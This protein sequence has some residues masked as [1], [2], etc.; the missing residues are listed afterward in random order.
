MTARL[1]ALDLVAVLVVATLWV[2]VAAVLRTGRSR[3]ALGLLAAAVLATAARVVLVAVLARSGWWFVQ[4]KV[5]LTVPLVVVPGVAA[6]VLAARALLGGRRPGRFA[7]ASAA[8]AAGGAATGVLGTFVVGYPVSTAAAVVLPLLVVAAAVVVLGPRVRVVGSG[9]VGLVLAGVVGGAWWGSRVPDRVEHTGHTG[10]AHHAVSVADLRGPPGEPTRRFT[11]TARQADVTL[12]GGRSV[13]AWTFDGQVPGPQLTV[14]QGDLVEVLLRN[15][16]I[17]DG[18]TIHWHGYPVPA[19]EDGVAGV[20]QDAVPPGGSFTYRFRATEPGTYWYHA[21]QRSLEAVRR[22]L[23]GA[24]VVRPPTP[25]PAAP[26]PRRDRAAAP[27][28]TP[29]GVDV[30]VPLHTMDGTLLTAPPVPDVAPRVPVRL[31]LINTDDRPHALVLHGTPYRLAAVDGRELAGG[32]PLGAD[33]VLPLPAGGR[34]DLVFTQPPRSVRLAVDGRDTGVLLGRDDG[35]PPPVLGGRL[36]DVTRYAP[37]GPPPWGPEPRFAVDTTLVLDRTLGFVDGLPALT[38]P[39]NGAVY[40]AV[41]DIVVRR[42]DLVRMTIVNRGSE[43][44]PMHPHGHAVLVLARDG[45]PASGPLWMD[46]FEVGPGEV[47]EVA[48][49]AD[50]PGLWMNHCHNLEHAVAG[51]VGHLAYEGVS[52][53]F[54]V[55]NATGNHPE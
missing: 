23:Y 10:H 38:Y 3:L 30:V 6:A 37:P 28:A 4:E 32:G 11:L 42:G 45:R 51:M 24:L 39:I 46:S 13:H 50:N 12:P 47:W 15:A 43:P 18:V 54:A 20:T 40:P 2:A 26:A 22:G 44:H 49:R 1:L 35:R 29:P 21:H 53:P 36:L 7:V 5:L 48:L 8:A 9:L 52:T 31:R 17:A 34:H 25:G 27:A 16:D 33:T 19:G 55:G 41:P 14:T